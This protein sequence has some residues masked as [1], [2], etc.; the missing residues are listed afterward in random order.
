MSQINY[1][2]HC[3]TLCPFCFID[4]VLSVLRF[5]A[6]DYLFDSFKLFL[7]ES[8]FTVYPILIKPVFR[9]H[10]SYVTPFQSF[11]VRSHNTGLT[12]FKKAYSYVRKQLRSIFDII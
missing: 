10:L 11:I 9:D 4:I 12:I 8:P 7:L 6:S 1:Y 3:L 5:T 2:V